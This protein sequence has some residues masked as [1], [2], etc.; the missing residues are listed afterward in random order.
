MPNLRFVE[1]WAAGIIALCS[2]LVSAEDIAARRIL[3]KD[4]A[5]PTKRHVQVQSKDAGVQDSEAG[6]P[7]ANGAAL[8]LYTATD[9]FCAILPGGADW[10]NI[11]TQ[12]K[13]KNKATRNVAQV[14]NGKLL[15]KIRSAVTFTIADDSMQGPVNAQVQFGNGTRYCMKCTHWPGIVPQGAVRNSSP[16]LRSP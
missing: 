12:W 6:D 4:D 13:Y 3:I 10:K 1:I 15:V 9:D 8:H 14:K 7:G 11:G 2:A 16:T 5:D